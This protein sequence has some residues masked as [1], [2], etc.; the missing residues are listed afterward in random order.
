MAICEASP[1]NQLS[2]ADTNWIPIFKSCEF[3]NTGRD[4][5]IRRHSSA[6]FCFELSGNLN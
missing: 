3:S 2:D 4:R 6:M 5:L 1:L